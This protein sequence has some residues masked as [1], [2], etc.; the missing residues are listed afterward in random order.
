M[1][2]QFDQ[3][4]QLPDVLLDDRFEL[5]IAPK[6][7]AAGFTE[8]LTLRCQSASMPGTDIEP[9]M[10]GLQGH[11]FHFRGRKMYG[12]GGGQLMVSYVETREGIATRTLK[13]WQEFIVG[14][15]SGAGAMKKEYATTATLRV[16]NEGDEIALEAYLENLWPLSVPDIQL[17]GQAAQVFLVQAS[18]QYDRVKYSG[19]NVL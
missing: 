15:N 8:A 11:T 9:V 14:S 3:L 1:P 12:G 16:Y 2:L 5:F 19:V 10:V 13:Q 6:G 17:N 18:F 4:D 7:D